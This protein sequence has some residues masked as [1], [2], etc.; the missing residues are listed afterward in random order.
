MD[1]RDLLKVDYEATTRYL[2]SLAD[3][4]LK[5]LVFVPTVTGLALA[6]LTKETD[7]MIPT[8]VGLFGLFVTLGVSYYDQRNT[9]I[10]DAMQIRAKTL[11]AHLGFPI[12]KHLELTVDGKKVQIRRSG[13]ILDRPRRDLYWFKIRLAPLQ[14]WHDCG[15]ALVYSATI[16]AWAYLS[17]HSFGQI[18][19]WSAWIAPAVAILVWLGVFCHYLINDTPTDVASA[20]LPEIRSLLQHEPSN[21]TTGGD[22][23]N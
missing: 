14:I 2:H 8:V 17:A 21:R 23:T 5:L 18:L 19:L 1:S 16:A 4:R 13:A 15:L 12:S 10:Y 9:R 7:G 11:E 20:L 6:T 3:S 22:S